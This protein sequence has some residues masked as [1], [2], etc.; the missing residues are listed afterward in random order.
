[1]YMKASMLESA[2]KDHSLIITYKCQRGNLQNMCKPV[3][4]Q[5]P[6]LSFQAATYHMKK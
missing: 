5:S 3:S 6:S 2:A 4:Y 1:M